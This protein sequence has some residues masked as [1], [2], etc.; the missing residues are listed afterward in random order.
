MDPDTKVK[1]S[2]INSYI[3]EKSCISAAVCLCLLVVRPVCFPGQVQLISTEPHDYQ[4]S[5]AIWSHSAPWRIS[6]VQK[7]L[8]QITDT[9]NS[10]NQLFSGEN[11]V[12]ECC[13]KLE[14][15]LERWHHIY[16]KVK[17]YKLCCQFVYSVYSVMK[18]K[19]I[20]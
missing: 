9:V 19:T 13:L 14:R 5:L 7:K 11:K 2:S 1:Y 6:N 18:M 12:P 15:W 8:H 4:L 16:N 20:C 3:Q 10:T 17:Q